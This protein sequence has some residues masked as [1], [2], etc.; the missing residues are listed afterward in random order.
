M[1]LGAQ[2][3]RLFLFWS[4][5]LTCLFHHHHSGAIKILTVLRKKTMD[6]GATVPLWINDTLLVFCMK[7]LL[8]S[9][10]DY[11]FQLGLCYLYVFVFVLFICTYSDLSV[12]SMCVCICQYVLFLYAYVRKRQSNFSKKVRNALLDKKRLLENKN[13]NIELTFQYFLEGY[14]FVTL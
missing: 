6:V 1:Y 3:Y 14:L 13:L 10:W 5:I 8:S 7:Q 11:V 12:I 4:N 9:K 2:S